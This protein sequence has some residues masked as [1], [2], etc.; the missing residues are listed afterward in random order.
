[1][2]NVINISAL[3]QFIQTV[4]SAEFSQQ[5]EVKM[6]IQQARLLCLTLTEIQAKLLQDYESLYHSLKQTGTTDVVN[7]NMDG[8]G[9]K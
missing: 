7:V 3:T 9:F 1:M 6:S 8:G 4:K 5:K 2:Q